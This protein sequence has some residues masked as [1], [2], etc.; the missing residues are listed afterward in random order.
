MAEE[1]TPLNENAD[2]TS[3]VLEQ[4]DTSDAEPAGT[5]E[6]EADSEK[7]ETEAQDGGNT[8]EQ[9]ADNLIFGKYKSIE[10]AEKGYKEAEKAITRSAELEKQLKAYREREEKEAV[11]RQTAAQK[12]GFNDA[13]EQQLDFA[14]KN[15]EF[16]RCVEALGATL[17]GDKYAEAYGHL[18]RYQTTL[19][20]RDLML[21]KAFFAPETIARIAEQTALYRQKATGEYHQQLQARHL[22]EIKGRVASF[23]KE[24]GD[25]LNPKERQDI[26]GLAVNI[27]GGNVDL[28]KVKELVD[29][30]E[31]SAVRAYQEKAKIEAENQQLQGSLQLPET[32][33]V[34]PA[35]E[36]W[37]TREEYNRMSEEQFEAN[38]EKIERQILLEKQGKLKPMLT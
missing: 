33:S 20:P 38:R 14:V 37:I 28:N 2:D 8:S 25:W 1:S 29:A 19:N 13:D 5:S 31:A 36:K 17:E 6:P 9:S 16:A 32:G 34:P 12:M 30:L 24:T 7:A 22:A 18:Q 10:D 21:A 4:A 35:G 27:T 26:V 11:A 3:D 23:A 15:F